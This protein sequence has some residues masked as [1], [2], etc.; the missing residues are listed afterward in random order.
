MS[1]L[2]ISK[3]SLSIG[4]FLILLIIV[5]IGSPVLQV[6]GIPV[7]G[8]IIAFIWNGKPKME[9]RFLFYILMILLTLTQVF[10]FWKPSYSF[11]FIINS[12]ISSCLWVLMLIASWSL[13]IIISNTPTYKIDK[14]LKLFFYVNLLIMVF[15]YGVISFNKG[16]LIP[17]AVNMGT[18]DFIKGIFT[19][20]SVSCII[21]SFYVVYFYY[22]KDLKRTILSIIC[23][24]ASTYMSGIV[25][26][27]IVSLFITVW[28]FGLKT[29]FKIFLGVVV[30]VYF[31]SVISPKNVDYV[32]ENLT[33]KLFSSTDQS[34]KIISFKQTIDYATSG[35]LEAVFGA[36][37]GKF[38]SRTAFLTSGD[39]ASWFPKKYVYVSPEFENHHL[40]LWN[41]KLL[42]Q[43]HKDGT[44][45]QPFSFYNKI[46]GEYGLIGFF[47]FLVLYIG[48]WMKNYSNLTYGKHLIL[49]MLAYFI[50]D[51]WF[52]YITVILFYELFILVDLKSKLENEKFNN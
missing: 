20:S 9:R 3:N 16:T 40:T 21:F 39:Y 46:F 36:G 26:F 1:N 10:L 30:G 49:F 37:G 43:P 17:Y 18:G 28:Y 8:T 29:K 7:F 38:S 25:I 31:F 6:V 19:N 13:S 14:G 11:G 52:D 24:L 15:Q 47:I 45:N 44:A 33:I 12:L 23:M 2:K 22:K 32:I 42:S 51:Y 5:S 35:V 48:N 4:L 50:L 34:R 41:S 27:V